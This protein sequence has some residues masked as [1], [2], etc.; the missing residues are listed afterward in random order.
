MGVRLS[1]DDFGTGYSS[2]LHLQSLPFDELKLDRSFVKSMVES[3]QSRKIT[4]TVIGLGVSLGLQTVCEG[5]ECREQAD[6][7]LWQGGGLGQGWLFGK[8]MPSEQLADFCLRPETGAMEGCE[9]A[10]SGLSVNLEA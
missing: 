1:L 2:L 6:L 10:V 5:I 7:L 3:R 9:S 8:P 4:A